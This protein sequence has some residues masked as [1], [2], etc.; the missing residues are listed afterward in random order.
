MIFWLYFDVFRILI[1][2]FSRI[3]SQGAR[4]SAAIDQRPL[5]SEALPGAMSEDSSTED[6]AIPDQWL[7][8]DITESGA[9]AEVVS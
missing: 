4:L 6:E 2:K 1:L 9:A 3:R 7:A 5:F 8:L